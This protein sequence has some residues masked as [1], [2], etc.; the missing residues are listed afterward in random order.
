MVPD[1]GEQPEVDVA[2]ARPLQVVESMALVE[3]E[4]RAQRPD[5]VVDIGLLR[6]SWTGDAEGERVGDMAFG[7]PSSEQ[8]RD[9]AAEFQGSVRAG[10]FIRPLK[11]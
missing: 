3:R 9:P 6:R 4:H 7:I 10:C 5:A 1:E 11:P 2:D 8:G